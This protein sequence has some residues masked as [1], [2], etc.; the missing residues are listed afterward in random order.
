MDSIL[1]YFKELTNR[2][3]E[4]FE[5]LES[6]YNEWNS[7]INVVSRKDIDELYTRHVLHSL[8]IAKLVQ[9]KP[10]TTVLD[11]G[12]GGGFPGIPLAILFPDVQF[13][14]T[15]SIGKKI[16][17]VNEVAKAL[18][19]SNVHG[20]Q[21]RAEKLPYRYHFIVS[22]A[23]TAFPKFVALTRKLIDNQ[24]INDIK[25]GIIYLKGGDFSDETAL[26]AKKLTVYPISDY[27]EEDFFET[28]KVIYLPL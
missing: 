11:V 17:V 2:Q 8:A 5:M 14:L 21:S 3:I 26:F 6:L 1:K 28:K 19:L 9:F 13:T 24:Q 7:K 12:C 4:Q 22:R 10:N 20:I 27:F 25:N 15:D 23:V 16:K 18:G